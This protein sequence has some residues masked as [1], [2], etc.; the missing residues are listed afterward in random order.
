MLLIKK[1]KNKFRG[2]LNKL[3]KKKEIFNPH[4]SNE[5]IK[6][7]ILKYKTKDKMDYDLFYNQINY[8]S[9]G[10]HLENY[11][12][13]CIDK[14]N[15]NDSW[16]DVG[17]GSGNVLK[18]AI[19]EKNI[20]LY[21]MDIVDKSI[22]NAIENGINCIKNSASSPY[23]YEDNFFNL[24]T[25]TDMLEHLHTNDVKPALKEIYRVLKSNHF[26][27]LAP[28]PRADKTG[29]LH[30]TVKSYEWWK[31]QCLEVGFEYIEFTGRDGLV[32][33]KN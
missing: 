9:P 20:N 16:L 26:A 2:V 11:F 19:E 12:K 10:I 30:L 6:N 13:Y 4:A 28:C 5:V 22:K 17:C 31:K 23:P 18:R 21:G 8:V 25:A 24:V 32:F 29:H 15:K 27:L 3:T 1:I 7:L 33:R 14:L